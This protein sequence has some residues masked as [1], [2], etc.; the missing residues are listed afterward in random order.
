[1]HLKLHERWRAEIWLLTDGLHLA[2]LRIYDH[3]SG[4]EWQ[5]GP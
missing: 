2:R 5:G 3:S 1:M 4:A